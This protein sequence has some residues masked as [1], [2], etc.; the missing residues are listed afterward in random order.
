MLYNY[1]DNRFRNIMNIFLK[2]MK[3][4]PFSTRENETALGIRKRAE[5][6]GHTEG[7]QVNFMECTALGLTK[8]CRLQFS[9]VSKGFD[10][11]L[12]GDL[13]EEGSL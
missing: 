9:D 10:T 8:C 1:T 2:E 7:Q 4:L 11:I 13:T 5:K 12:S 6:E 3:C